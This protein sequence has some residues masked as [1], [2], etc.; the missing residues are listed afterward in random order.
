MSR[1]TRAGITSVIGGC[2][3]CGK[4]WE[5][6]NTLALAAKHHDATGHS[7]WVEQ[8]LSVRYGPK[9]SA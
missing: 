2:N 9:V 3:V 5:S 6:K 7:T 1:E 8:V 4:V